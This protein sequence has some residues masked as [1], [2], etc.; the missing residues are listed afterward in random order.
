MPMLQIRGQSRRGEVAIRIGLT[1][2]DFLV[3]EGGRELFQLIAQSLHAN[4]SAGDELAVAPRVGRGGAGRRLATSAWNRLAHA[5][6]GRRQG[7]VPDLAA[8]VGPAI[9]LSQAGDRRFDVVG[10]FTRPPFGLRVPWLGYIPDVQHRRLPD[11]FCVDERERRDRDF[12]ALLGQASAVLVNAADVGQDLR[13]FYPD[14]RAKILPLPFAACARPEWFDGGD[15]VRVRYGIQGPFFLCSNQFWKHKNH[16]LV[17]AAAA[18]AKGAGAPVRF[19]FTGD[20]RDYRHPGYFSE[21]VAE[22]ESAGIGDVVDILGF[23]PKRDQI[24]LMLEAEAVVQPSLFEGG[25]GGGS[26]YNAIALGRRVVVSDLPVNREIEGL[27]THYFD[28]ADPGDLLDKLRAVRSASFEPKSPSVLLREGEAR[29]R[30]FGLALR[31]AFA[32][33]LEN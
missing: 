33:A 1:P 9:P 5:V 25:P 19:V 12:A 29:R 11:M 28:P 20:T 6:Q 16:R 21:L 32:E 13:R 31:N 30:D 14:A 15:D 22:I 7:E 17:I 18:L 4:L 26:I 3:W 10:P 23:I 27:V 2:R 24:R 8:L